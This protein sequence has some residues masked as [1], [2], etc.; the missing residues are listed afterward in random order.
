MSHV[1]L[2]HLIIIIIIIILIK[3]WKTADGTA[4]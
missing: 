3:H 4:G 2:S 1:F